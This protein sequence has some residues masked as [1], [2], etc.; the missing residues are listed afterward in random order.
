MSLNR[1]DEVFTQKKVQNRVLAKHFDK[2]ES[3][4]SKW[5]NNKRQPS[6]EQ[7]K[8][9][10][11]LLRMNIKDLFHDTDWSNDTSETY[12]DIKTKYK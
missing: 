1:L 6:I 2:S 7:F 12:N 3:T 11:Q 9:I 10:A 4:I 5:R 8:E